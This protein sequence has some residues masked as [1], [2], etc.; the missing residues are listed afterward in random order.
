M[1][2]AATNETVAVGIRAAVPD[3]AP[4]MAAIL[5]EVGW[6]G[7]GP[8]TDEAELVA[9]IACRRRSKPGSG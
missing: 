1:S 9:R 6:A 7:D 8:G 3:D 2:E 4:A 5:T